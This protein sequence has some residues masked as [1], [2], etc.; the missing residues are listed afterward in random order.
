MGALVFLGG[1]RFFLAGALT[2]AVIWQVRTGNFGLHTFTEVMLCCIDLGDEKQ[3]DRKLKSEYRCV[4][5]I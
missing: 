3:N 4:Y 2:L 5:G 1:A